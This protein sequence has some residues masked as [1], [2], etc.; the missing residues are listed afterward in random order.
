MSISFILALRWWTA[1]SVRC[2]SAVPRARAILRPYGGPGPPGRA[3]LFLAL[4]FAARFR[5]CASFWP[6]L[7]QAPARRGP[8]AGGGGGRAP[9]GRRGWG[10]RGEARAG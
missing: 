9:G 8:G 7:G 4:L 10:G 1:T 6:C 2:F 5:Q 3:L